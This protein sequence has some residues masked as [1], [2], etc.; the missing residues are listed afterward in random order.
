MKASA[1]QAEITIAFNLL[2]H[3]I[4]ELQPHSGVLNQDDGLNHKISS[5]KGTVYSSSE[6]CSSANVLIF[7]YD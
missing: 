2:L 1:S 6:V 5:T 4:Y 3:T 7:F